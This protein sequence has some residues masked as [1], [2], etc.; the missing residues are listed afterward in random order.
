M[1]GEVQEHIFEPFFSTK[2]V[3]EG[4]GLGLAA[5]YGSVRQLGGGIDVESAMG[6]GVDVQDLFA[7]QTARAGGESPGDKAGPASRR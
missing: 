5:V 6:K 1:T 7:R 2:E 4:T 3:G